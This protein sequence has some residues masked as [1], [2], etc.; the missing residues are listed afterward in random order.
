MDEEGSY[1]VVLQKSLNCARISA[2]QAWLSVDLAPILICMANWWAQNS[3]RDLTEHFNITF[4]NA[5]G[6]VEGLVSIN[7]VDDVAAQIAAQCSY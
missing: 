2:S 7:A 5:L 1:G 3:L 6:L 4:D